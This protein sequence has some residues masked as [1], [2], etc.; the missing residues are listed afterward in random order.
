MIL[1]AAVATAHARLMVVDR[2]SAIWA[3]VVTTVR[4]KDAMLIRS[5]YTLG[6]A[7]V[8]PPA[9]AATAD[10]RLLTVACVSVSWATVPCLQAQEPSLR[11]CRR[12]TPSLPA[13]HSHQT[14][15]VMIRGLSVPTTLQ[16]RPCRRVCRTPLVC[17]FQTPTVTTTVNG[18]R[19]GAMAQL[20]LQAAACTRRRRL[21]RLIAR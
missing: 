6:A 15:T 13:G 5:L 1:C 7:T 11:R 9:A 16:K 17:T 10:A 12:A 20:A 18:G 19:A 8:T 14:A 21:L 4:L 3:G 2:A